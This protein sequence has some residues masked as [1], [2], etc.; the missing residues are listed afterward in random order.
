MTHRERAKH[1]LS[2]SLRVLALGAEAQI[3][4]VRADGGHLDELGL[5]FDDALGM[6]LLGWSEQAERLIATIDQLLDDMS[7]EANADLWTEAAL[8][9]D[10]RWAR[11]RG[12]AAE[13]LAAD[14]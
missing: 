7:G 6:G 3:A 10:P 9:V 13:A 2:E 14:P 12:L 5:C 8:L 11:V 1:L 4:W